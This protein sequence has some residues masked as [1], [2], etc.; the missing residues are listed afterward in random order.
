MDHGHDVVQESVAHVTNKED[1]IKKRWVQ[2]IHDHVIHPHQHQDLEQV[3]RGVH[4]LHQQSGEDGHYQIGEQ[5]WAV[6]TG[7]RGS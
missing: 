1:Q 2:P 5:H 6:S 4:G 3:A 7:A